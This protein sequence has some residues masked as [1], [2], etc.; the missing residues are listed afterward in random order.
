MFPRDAIFEHVL[1]LDRQNTFKE[2]AVCA[3]ITAK[4]YQRRRHSQ[5]MV[6]LPES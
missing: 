5:K 4:T 1:E 2:A 3:D 6:C